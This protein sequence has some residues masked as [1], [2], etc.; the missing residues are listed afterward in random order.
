MDFKID[1][2]PEARAD[3]KAMRALNALR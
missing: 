1:F 2:D 3:L